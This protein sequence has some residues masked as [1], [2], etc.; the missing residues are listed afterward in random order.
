MKMRHLD[1]KLKWWKQ[2]RFILWLKSMPVWFGTCPSVGSILAM[3]PSAG[4]LRS[5][6]GF[7]P[8]IHA[9]SGKT[10]SFDG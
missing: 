9:T 8:F 4:G 3:V 1:H 10:D 6:A 5:L 2:L 7:Y